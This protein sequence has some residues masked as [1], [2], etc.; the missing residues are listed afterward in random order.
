MRSCSPMTSTLVTLCRGVDDRLTLAVRSSVWKRWQPTTGSFCEIK[1]V[2]GNTT[3]STH[4]RCLQLLTVPGQ[5]VND[6]V[7]PSESRGFQPSNYRSNSTL[8]CPLV[9]AN[10]FLVMMRIFVPSIKRGEMAEDEKKDVMKKADNLG[11]RSVP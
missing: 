8:D 9:A 3:I 2:I 6:K 1:W 4:C 10:R 11:F 7:S 5:A